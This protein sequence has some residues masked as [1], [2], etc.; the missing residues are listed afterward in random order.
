MKSIHRFHRFVSVV[1]ALAGGVLG[2]ALS[3]P[4]A[5]AMRVPASGGT[6][7]SA[8]SGQP[9]PIVAHTTL[10]GGMLGWQITVIAVG[11]ALFTATV[12]VFVDRARAG[13]RP[14]GVSAA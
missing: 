10:A 3:A 6:S 14:V 5:F 11:V 2:F 8:V 13:R 12:A 4:A 7:S 9:A 1:V